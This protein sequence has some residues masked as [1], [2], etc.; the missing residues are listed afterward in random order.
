MTCQPPVLSAIFQPTIFDFQNQN[1]NFC[2]GKGYLRVILKRISKAMSW[3]RLGSYDLNI[4]TISDSLASSGPQVAC[5][6]VQADASACQTMPLLAC[7]EQ[8]S[9]ALACSGVIQQS[10]LPLQEPA[11]TW[12]LFGPRA[13]GGGG[14]GGCISSW[15]WGL[16]CFLGHAPLVSAW[17]RQG[18]KNTAET[19]AAASSQQLLL[20]SLSWNQPQASMWPDLAFGEGPVRSV[21]CTFWVA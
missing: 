12:W 11:G 21:T 4:W 7:P 2:L 6:S 16:S 13:G 18:A 9:S 14:C 17:R 5:Q 19:W 15:R 8:S 10:I 1:Q 20:C 3:I